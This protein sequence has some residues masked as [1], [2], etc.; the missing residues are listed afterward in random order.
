MIKY[1]YFQYSEFRAY[2]VFQGNP[3]VAQKSW[4][5]KN[6]S[7]GG[8]GAV[9][10]GPLNWNRCPPFHVWPT[11]CCIHSILYFKNVPLLLVF[12]PSFGFLAPPS[13]VWPLVLVFAPPL[14]LHPGDGPDFITVKSFRATLFFRER[15]LFKNL[16]DKKS[17]TCRQGRQGREFLH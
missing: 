2:S 6:I 14:L 11:G 16:N 10:P 9:V 15:K 8:G 7:S 12:G 17:V 13:S 1:I 3:Q 4:K 5:M